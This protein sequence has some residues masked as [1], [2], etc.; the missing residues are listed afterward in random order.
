MCYAEG[1]PQFIELKQAFL[2]TEQSRRKD[3]SLPV[4]NKLLLQVYIL[5]GGSVKSWPVTEAFLQKIL[6]RVVPKDW[7]RTL[8]EAPHLLPSF[9]SIVVDID[10]L[11]E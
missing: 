8:T 10:G 9:L 3:I 6:G 5:K 2:A 4:D 11:G 1:S 7:M